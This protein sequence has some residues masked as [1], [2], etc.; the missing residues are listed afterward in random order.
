MRAE[1]GPPAAWTRLAGAE[2]KK[3]L[4]VMA[5]IDTGASI[6]VINPQIAVTSGLR[7]VGIAR[8]STTGLVSEM[9]E[10]TA[11]IHFPNSK[12]KGFDPVRVIACPLPGSEFSCIIG[13]D[14]LEKWRLVYDGRT[15]EVQIEE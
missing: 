1:I 14:I 15:G 5:L 11:A 12:L 8:I 9:P 13:R 3:P 4:T 10:Y 7:Q 6:T 2:P